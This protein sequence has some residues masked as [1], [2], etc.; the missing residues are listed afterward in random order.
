MEVSIT[1]LSYSYP[2]QEKLQLIIE[3]QLR[4]NGEAYGIALMVSAELS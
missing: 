1:K 2:S 3:F 4:K